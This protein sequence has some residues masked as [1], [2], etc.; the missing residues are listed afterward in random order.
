MTFIY[1]INLTSFL[2]RQTHVVI[3]LISRH[4]LTSNASKTDLIL[5][6][7]QR[8]LVAWDTICVVENIFE[9][10]ETYYFVVKKFAIMEDLYDV[11]I[12]SPSLGIYKCSA[13]SNNFCTI[14]IT[15][16]QSKCY[17]MP[18][19]K[20]VDDKDSDSNTDLDDDQ[21]VADKYIVSVLFIEN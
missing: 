7:L 16:I 4:K 10:N 11:G 9:I 14:S 6:S 5:T 17:M 1:V 20:I 13:L 21:P 8:Q 18:Y 2:T 19:W 12:S 15:D 3:T